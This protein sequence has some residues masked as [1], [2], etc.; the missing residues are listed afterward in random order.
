MNRSILRISMS[1]VAAGILS[2]GFAFVPSVLQSPAMAQDADQAILLENGKLVQENRETAL[3]IASKLGADPD[4]GT[5]AEKELIASLEKQNSSEPAV[6]NRILFLKNQLTFKSI[7][8]KAGAAPIDTPP[9]TA[10]SMVEQNQA[11]LMQNRQVLK[12]AADK[13]GVDLGT[14][15]PLA[16]GSKAV[17]N[18]A[19]LKANKAALAKFVAKLGS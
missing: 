6:K 16:E 18:N 8:A 2:T 1:L 19:L 7:A 11:T 17:Q 10:G 13:L 3:K 5:A 4:F 15:A 9:S 12:S 14:P